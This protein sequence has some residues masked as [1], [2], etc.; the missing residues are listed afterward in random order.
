MY[1]RTLILV[2]LMR[3]CTPYLRWILKGAV[4]ALILLAIAVT[5]THQSESGGVTH[6]GA[7]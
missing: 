5:L 1:T 6:P 3:L 7:T 2:S 4:V